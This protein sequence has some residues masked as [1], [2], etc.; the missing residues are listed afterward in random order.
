MGSSKKLK[1][2]LNAASKVALIIILDVIATAGSFFSDC[3]SGQISISRRSAYG[4]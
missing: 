3:G 2:R 1:N 4:I